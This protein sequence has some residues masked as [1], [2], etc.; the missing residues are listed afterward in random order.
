MSQLEIHLF[1]YP[2]AILDGKVLK[3]ERRKT[4]A[5]LAYIA[6][7]GPCPRETLNT[8][9]W[10]ELDPEQSGAYLR[11]SLWEIGKIL[12]DDCLVKEGAQVRLC[13]EKGILCDA[14]EFIEL[15]AQTGKGDLEPSKTYAVLCKAVALQSDDF[16]KGFTLKDS[17]DFDDWQSTQVENL[18]LILA[19]KLAVLAEFDAARGKYSEALAFARRRLALDSLDEQSHR[20]VMRLLDL[21]GQTSAA[22]RQYE[23]CQQILHEQLGVPPEAETTRLQ[24]EIMTRERSVPPETGKPSHA[25]YFIPPVPVYLPAQSTQF[26]GRDEEIEQICEIL[27]NPECRMLTIVGPGGSGK[28]RLAIQAANRCASLTDQKAILFPDGIYY[29]SLANL[30]LPEQIPP[31]LATALRLELNRP[32]THSLNSEEAAQ[33]VHEYLAEKVLLLVL[34]NFEQLADQGDFLVKLLESAPALKVLITSRERL[35]LPGEWVFELGGMP[36]PATG[37]E[38]AVRSSQSGQ[39]FLKGAQR[40]GRFIPGQG[41][42]AEIARICQMVD[43]MPLGIELAAAW[44]RIFSPVEIATELARS[45]DFLDGPAGS[46]RT[47][48]RTGLRAAFEHSWGLLPATLKD[49]FARLSVFRGGFSREAA[50]FVAGASLHH[51][52]AL[53]DRSLLRRTA[54]GR[55]D[56]HEIL[57]QFAAEKLT[58]ESANST[59][60]NQHATYF[61]AWM[62]QTG[63]TLKGPRQVEAIDA[64]QLEDLNLRQAWQTALNHGD[65]QKIGHIIP[66]FILYHEMHGL[67]DPGNLAMHQVLQAL[68]SR[69]NPVEWTGLRAMAMAALERFSLGPGAA[70]IDFQTQMASLEMARGLPDGYEK[71]YIYM[72]KGV[73]LHNLIAQ[74]SLDLLMESRSIFGRLG[75]DWGHALATLVTADLANFTSMDLDLAQSLYS[76]CRGSFERLHNPW[77]IA[78]AQYGL[79]ILAERENR[80]AEAA[81]MTANS[82]EIF[83]NLGDTGRMLQ[84]RQNLGDL[85]LKMGRTNEAIRYFSANRDFFEQA[86]N[87]EIAQKYSETIHQLGNAPGKQAERRL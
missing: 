57:K 87:R 55:F 12:G 67:R 2:N 38:T 65:F 81:A 82:L 76:E 1:G 66:L 64:L 24:R 49:I 6:M 78:L 35:N 43:G 5:L 68:E 71:A 79:A 75:D 16:L 44:V 21:S 86:G 4:L 84:L 8:L 58:D 36:V 77:G 11:H 46:Q 30:N 7:E 70:P 28:T 53:T 41:D 18:R 25:V 32:V 37:S 29:A 39:L 59:T 56:L 20:L 74:A 45:V 9:F 40:T 22:L 13:Y 47:G 83:T 33:Q 10:P 69:D 48:A 60:L 72:M 14:K 26:I 50:Q 85:N 19:E 34:D 62:E 31:I 61:L 52:V 23:T 3:L 54:S 73:G 51:L 63:E 27:E 80:L 42:W 15:I 17:L